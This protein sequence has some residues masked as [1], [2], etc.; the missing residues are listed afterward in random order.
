MV[1]NLVKSFGAG[2]PLFQTEK[3]FVATMQGQGL[4]G[5]ILASMG[6]KPVNFTNPGEITKQITLKSKVFSIY[7]TGVVKGFRRTTKVTIHA[8]VDYRA[9][10]ALGAAFG[11]FPQPGGTGATG[12]PNAAA[13]TVPPIGGAGATRNNQ[14][15]S[16]FI[17]TLADEG[18]SVLRTGD[19]DSARTRVAP[20]ST[21]P[22]IAWKKRP[23]GERS[24]ARK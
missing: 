12:Q 13:T 20:R 4:L 7:A 24:L 23:A 21:G 14:D 2:I 3:D 9:A 15:P 1:M 18:F 22:A 10:S 6:V 5:P 8:V 17:D 19:R 11:Q 16:Q